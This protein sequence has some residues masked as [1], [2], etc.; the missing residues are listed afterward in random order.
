MRNGFSLI[1]IL[2]GVVIIAL[3]VGGV[4]FSFSS[5]AARKEL[6]SAHARVIA[7]IAH[8]RQKTLAGE[9]AAAWGVH[10][11]TE[12]AVL[13]KVPWNPSGV[14]N[15]VER[16][17][18]RASI[19]SLA[20]TNDAVVFARLTGAANAGSVTLSLRRDASVFRTI[21]VNALGIIE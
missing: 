19:S 16:M 10:F 4:G 5:Y 9:H 15:R 1:E 20:F 21:S 13:F 17:P 7:L 2:V 11:E 3:V 8:A 12:Q 14:D 6:E 18:R